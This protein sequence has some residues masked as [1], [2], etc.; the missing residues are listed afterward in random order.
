MGF[1]LLLRVQ[2][3]VVGS[4]VSPG[5][6]PA[7]PWFQGAARWLCRLETPVKSQ[8]SSFGAHI[9]IINVKAKKANQEISHLIAYLMT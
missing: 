7:V 1:A 4:D 6:S 3:E 2:G 5:A 8:A 9:E